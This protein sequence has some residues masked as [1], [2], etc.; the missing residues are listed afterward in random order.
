MLGPGQNPLPDEFGIVYSVDGNA[1]RFLVI[2]DSDP[3]GGDAI[4]T[5]NA[6]DDRLDAA[7]CGRPASG[8]DGRD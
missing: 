4:A 6:L 8:R 7:A 1:A 5:I 2:L 3:L